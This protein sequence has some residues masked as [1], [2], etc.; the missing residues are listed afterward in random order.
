MRRE[1][2]AGRVI[3]AVVLLC[4]AGVGFYVWPRGPR[5]VIPFDTMAGVGFTQIAQERPVGFDL[6]RGLL[7][8]TKHLLDN[9]GFELHGFELSSGELK[10]NVPIPIE[11]IT[12]PNGPHD[13]SSLLSEDGSTLICWN[14]WGFII[15]VFE[16]HQQC[17]SLCT[18]KM[19]SSSMD[20]ISLS[21]HGELLAFRHDDDVQLWNCKEGKIIRHLTMPAETIERLRFS[22]YRFP[23]GPEGLQFSGD[24]QHL[25]VAGDIKGTVVFET[26]SGQVIGQCQ[27]GWIPHFLTGNK[28]LL[29][30][31]GRISPGELKR[32]EIEQQK[33]KQLTHTLKIESS[34]LLLGAG[35]DR[36]FTCSIEE[37]ENKMKSPAWIP[38]TIREWIDSMYWKMN[39]P[40]TVKAWD[41]SSGQL[42]DEFQITYKV[43]V[44]SYVS[45]DGLY[46]AIEDSNELA[47][48]DLPPRRSLTC[49]LICSSL[50]AFAFWIGWSRRRKVSSMTA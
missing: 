39:R 21:C 4:V 37:I 9:K 24:S 11:N 6:K 46:L 49:W 33:L 35:K 10:V 3:L 44:L 47:L 22:S 41:A 32:Y 18:I 40:L 45:P 29:V 36:F 16:V 12:T 28:T 7:F 23:H 20:S 30:F 8:T 50:A 48:W 13:W 38:A 31:P 5:W 27:I 42:A 34:A 15:Q 25:A 14:T 43:S 2:R 19:P 26:A 1:W 17:R